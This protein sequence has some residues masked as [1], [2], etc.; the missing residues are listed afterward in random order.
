MSYPP[1]KINLGESRLREMKDWKGCDAPDRIV[2]EGRHVTLVP[3]EEGHVEPLWRALGAE[4]GINERLRYF[5]CPD[6]EVSTVFGDW[7][8]EAQ[9]D[10]LTYV[11]LSRKGGKVVGM[12]SYMRMDPKNGVIEVGSVAHGLAMARSPAATEVHYLMAQHVFDDLGYRRYEWKCH[13]DNAPSKRT[14]ERLGFAF[15]GIFRQHLVSKGANRDTA[16]FSIIDGE[17][18]LVGRAMEAWLSPANFNG[19]DRQIARLEDIRRS[20]VERPAEQAAAC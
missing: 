15:E 4:G 20:L 1:R 2:M 10:W 17:W 19:E 18:P 5:P 6:F 13:N 14:A 8:S 11:F 3:F 9:G 7:L 16:W 12:A